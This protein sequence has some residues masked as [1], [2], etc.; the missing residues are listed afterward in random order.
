[1]AADSFV[2][3]VVALTVFVLIAA[4]VLVP[5]VQDSQNS[6]KITSNNT[7]ELFNAVDSNGSDNVTI[8]LVGG[9]PMVNDYVVT[10]AVDILISD[11]LV[12]F[13]SSGFKVVDID[14][15]YIGGISGDFTVNDGAYSYKTSS[16]VDKSG[17]ISGT[18]LY[19][20]ENGRYGQF[21]SSA[22][23]NFNDNSEIYALLLTSTLSTVGYTALT[24]V[25]HGSINDGFTSS[26]YDFQTS[27]FVDVSS[28]ISSE[29]TYTVSPYGYNTSSSMVLTAT[30][31]DD[32]QS[33]GYLHIYAPIEY[34]MYDDDGRSMASLLNI[35]PLMVFIAAIMIAVGMLRGKS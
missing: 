19:L 21:L 12:V 31:G 32:S 17:T 30:V 27:A 23:I 35:I 25:T 8:G 2:Y 20:A 13:Y 24:A 1:M 34:K 4:T 28:T 15:N 3:K 5:V 11:K 7:A 22:A 26:A 9:V 10:G 18:Y 33:N 16:E 14:N 6:I 29:L